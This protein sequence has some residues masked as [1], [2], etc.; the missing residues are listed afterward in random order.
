[1]ATLVDMGGA[2]DAVN[3][4]VSGA[5]T[6]PPTSLSRAEGIVWYERLMAQFSAC[7]GDAERFTKGL[8]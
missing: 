5:T 6:C 1:M 3:V 7:S 2:D 4:A 8:E